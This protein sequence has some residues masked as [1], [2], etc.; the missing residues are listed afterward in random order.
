MPEA[1]LSLSLPLSPKNTLMGF[2][3]CLSY[4]TWLPSTPSSLL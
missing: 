2:Q 1:S 3:K 4:L